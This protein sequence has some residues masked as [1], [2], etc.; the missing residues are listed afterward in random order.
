MG[1]LSYYKGI[2]YLL[3]AMKK[4]DAKLIIV[5]AGPLEEKLK[6][7]ISKMGI[8]DRIVFLGRVGDDELINLY[9]ACAVFAL[10]SIYKSEAFGVVLIEAMACG[11]PIISTELGT[12]TSWVNQ[13]G[14]T[15]FVV[16]PRNV[17][18]LITA[19]NKIL[20]NRGLAKELGE[21]ARKRVIAKFTLEKMIEK[22]KNLYKDLYKNL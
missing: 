8:G 17:K 22:H 2:D 20:E 9:N 5:G 7:L 6:G 10:P 19:I 11:K 14:K 4:V 1:R 16:K 12:G 15:G 18:S 21:N 3:R 13:D